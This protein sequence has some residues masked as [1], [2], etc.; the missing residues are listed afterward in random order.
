[1]TAGTEKDFT[2]IEGAAAYESVS[3]PNMG[4]NANL[5]ITA[6]CTELVITQLQGCTPALGTLLNLAASCASL[7]QVNQGANRVN[8]AL[9]NIIATTAAPL[10]SAMALPMTR[11]IDINAQTRDGEGGVGLAGLVAVIGTGS[12]YIYGNAA[13]CWWRVHNMIRNCMYRVQMQALIGH[14]W[15]G[16]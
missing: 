3:E 5:C 7:F 1:M 10:P 2:T 6:A 14:Q 9:N 8:Q 16:S 12:F 4:L 15:I 13:C 11:N